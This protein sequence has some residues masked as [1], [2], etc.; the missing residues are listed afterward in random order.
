MAPKGPWHRWSGTDSG[1]ESPMG[2]CS[3]GQSRKAAWWR[4][5]PSQPS[6]AIAHNQAVREGWEVASRLGHS[7]GKAR[8]QDL[9][10][11]TA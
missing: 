1:R 10:V 6:K 5:P 7:T 3:T 4:Q 11:H 2:L 9:A 8:R